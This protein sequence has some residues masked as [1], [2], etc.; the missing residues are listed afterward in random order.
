[1]LA[2]PTALSVAGG[3]A[4]N[5]TSK[6]TPC[7][8]S[9]SKMQE[10]DSVSPSRRSAGGDDAT[11]SS[12]GSGVVQNGGVDPVSTRMSSA[13]AVLVTSKVT[14]RWSAATCTLSGA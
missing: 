10:F 14:V 1:M 6:V 7:C 12:S 13:P 8:S 3:A 9:N 11:T 4:D 2:L 5:A